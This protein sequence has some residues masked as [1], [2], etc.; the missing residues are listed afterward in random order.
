M[1]RGV[2]AAVLLLSTGLAAAEPSDPITAAHR[3]VE[4]CTAGDLGDAADELHALLEA[5]ES[6]YGPGHDAPLIVRLNLAEIE[7]RLGNHRRAKKIGNLRPEGG[8]RT[9]RRSIRNSSACQQNFEVY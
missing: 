2:L 8:P 1:Y 5:L 7:R 4:L 3:A 6:R 9:H